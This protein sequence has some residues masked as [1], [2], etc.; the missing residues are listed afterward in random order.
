MRTSSTC[1][2]DYNFTIS[3]FWSPF[4]IK[5]HLE[6]TEGPNGT[7]LWDLYLDEADDRWSSEIKSYD[8]II[9]SGGNWF[10]RPSKFFVDKKLIGCHFCLLNNVTDLTLR[11]SHRA[12]FHTA[13]STLNKMENFK[14]QVIVITCYILFNFATC[15]SN[16][17]FRFDVIHKINFICSQ[18]NAKN[19]KFK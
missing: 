11:Y 6:D 8:Y 18:F 7:G 10:T 1:Y 2:S 3:I 12:A 17:I 4:L 9:F 14:G 5:A 19:L 13:F 16:I 15:S